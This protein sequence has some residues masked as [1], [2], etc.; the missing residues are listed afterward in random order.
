MDTILKSG[1]YLYGLA[2]IAFGILQFINDI[3]VVGRAP[4][5][6]WATASNA[7]TW[8]YVSGALLVAA[9][10]AVL[11]NKKARTAASIVGILILLG[12]VIRFIPVV[13][14]DKNFGGDWTNFFKS[15]ALAG[16]SFIIA[17]SI[18]RESI[19]KNTF[20]DLISKLIPAGRFL[21]AAFFIVGGIQHFMFAE[22]VT[23]LVPAW[24]PGKLF[25]TYFAGIALLAAGAGLIIPGTVRLAALLSGLMIFTW[26]LILHIPRALASP[27]EVGEQLGCIETLAFSGILFVLADLFKGTSKGRYFL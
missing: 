13:L 11:V 24:I 19:A 10:V 2:L 1:R 26:M 27:H 14:A 16:G 22:F 25:W 6:E 23:T 20:N 15:L 3:F 18:P 12:P 17:G 5:W 9:G 21:I 4:T 7:T 8:A